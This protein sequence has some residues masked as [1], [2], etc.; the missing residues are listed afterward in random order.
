MKDFVWLILSLEVT[1]QW[2][3]FEESEVFGKMVENCLECF[4]I[5]LFNRN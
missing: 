2:N 4:Q 5:Y 3:I 1:T